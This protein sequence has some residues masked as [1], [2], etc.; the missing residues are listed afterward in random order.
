MNTQIIRRKA[1]VVFTAVTLGFVTLGSGV[2]LWGTDRPELTRM[3]TGQK[4]RVEGVIVEREAYSFIVRDYRGG[5]YKVLLQAETEI[6]EKKRNPFRGAIKYSADDLLP[7]LNVKVAGEGDDSGSV[8]AREIKFTRDDLK[9]AETIASRVQPLESELASTR[10]RLEGR[11]ELVEQKTSQFSADL[12]EMEAAYQKTSREIETT[13]ADAQQ[14]Q[15]TA[16][17]AVAGVEDTNERI[18][19]L[20]HYQAEKELSI[21]FKFDSA[22]LMP[23]AQALLDEI[24]EAAKESRGFLIEIKGYASAEGDDAYNRILSDRR[25]KAVADYLSVKHLI[26]PRR[27]TIPVGYGELYPVGDNS[28][29]EGRQKNRRVEVRMLVNRA[30]LESVE[31]SAAFLKKETQQVNENR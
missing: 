25:A 7:G 26:E 4:T 28:K 14:A 29:R 19:N 8:L 31:I 15:R 12:E 24:A 11:L 21:P 13:R 23:E 5:E 30:L 1:M 6:G 17:L 18:S 10:N 16:Q 20:D 3:P 9:V 2:S 27:I 22:E